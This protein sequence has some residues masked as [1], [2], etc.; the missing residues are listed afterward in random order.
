MTKLQAE[1]TSDLTHAAVSV[2]TPDETF[3][4]LA[5]IC[6]VTDSTLSR[7]I[8]MIKNLT[9]T[10]DLKNDESDRISHKTHC[11]LDLRKTIVFFSFYLVLKVEFAVDRIFE[12]V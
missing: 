6:H 7:K 5:K 11:Q 8:L 10:R 2:S 3:K 9:T 1:M 4:W 12:N